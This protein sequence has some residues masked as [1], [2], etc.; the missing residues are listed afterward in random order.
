MINKKAYH[1]GAFFEAIGEDF[2]SLNKANGIINADV[3]DAWFNPSPK[4]IKK[5]K[6][7]TEFIIR[8]SPPTHCKGLIKTISKIKDIPIENIL[9][10]GGSSDIMFAIFPQLANKKTK[11]LILD[12][13]YGEYAHIFENVT[14]SKLF[15]HK[16]FKKNDFKINITSLQKDINATKPDLV[17][18]VNPN[19]PTGKYCTKEA[20]LN[21]IKSNLDKLFIIDETYVEYV[22]KKQSLEKYTTK[23]NNLIV[24]KSMSKIY[25]LSGA[26]VAYM[27]ANKKII[28]NL[29]SFIPPWSVSLLG[30]I[31]GVEALKDPKYYQK[32]Y[33]KTH[34]LRKN[35]IKGLS[36]IS[37]I[38]IFDSM[39][40]FF[41]VE[42]INPKLS[43]KNIV[44][45][46]RK[47]KIYLRNCDSMSKQFKNDFVRITVREEKSNNKV[48]K[49][50]R[51]ELGKLDE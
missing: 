29:S 12:P 16:L 25:A 5:I 17:V 44:N 35:F 8:T 1:G 49:A 51:K 14:Q 45:N 20:V 37:S 6:K 34:N 41:L 22:D 24:I 15:R 18:L 50:L 43:A 36:D 31:A 40:N 11:V 27:V 13:M 33:N 30:Q 42:L 4:V 48:T 23:L 39:A 19:S 10:G 21:L 26:R 38:K 46:L 47:Q 3:L 32:Q 9:V 2:S 7:Y 28:N